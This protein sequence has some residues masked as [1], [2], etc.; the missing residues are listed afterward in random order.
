MRP[1]LAIAPLAL[2]TLAATTGCDT[3]PQR[4]PENAAAPAVATPAVVAPTARPVTGPLAFFAAPVDTLVTLG[5]WLTTHPG[6]V[7]SDRVPQGADRELTCRIASSRIDVG[8]RMA[9]RSALFSIP[10]APAGEAL[11]SDTSRVAERYCRL[12]AIWLESTEP[13]ST[14][15]RAFADSLSAVVDGALGPSRAGVPLHGPGTGRWYGGRA[16]IGPGTTIVLGIVPRESIVD[17]AGKVIRAEPGQV[18]LVAFAPHSGIDP[19]QSA[20]EFID[21]DDE[22]DFERELELG[23]ADSS[24]AWAAL[25][26]LTAEIGPALARLRAGASF[27]SLHSAAIDSGVLK[28]AAFVHDTAPRLEPRR[29]AAALLATDIVVNGFFTT[30]DADSA[31]AREREARSAIGLTYDEDR[32][33]G[34][35]RFMRPGLW[36]AYR[37]DPSGPAGRAALVTLLRSGWA[38]DA[39]CAEGSDEFRRVIDQGEAA[40]ARGAGDALIHYYVGIAYHDIVSLAQGGVP[41]LYSDPSD[42]APL[43]PAARVRAIE[44]LRASLAQPGDRRMRRHAWRMAMSLMLGRSMAPRYFCVYD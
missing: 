3:T 15:A 2:A 37:I 42:Y 9:V 18:V 1:R 23:R 7:S 6:D 27:G 31:H 30:I 26:R 33:D 10:N 35:Y 13:D 17:D 25:P 20:M 12:S 41:D 22:R 8:G 40:L 29:R 11:P 36:E 34:S 38:T 16:W 14:R 28:A 19:L 5:E 39:R 43:A 4:S 24:L 21:L 44:H 32:L